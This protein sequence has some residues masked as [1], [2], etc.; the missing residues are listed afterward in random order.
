VLE[1]ADIELVRS[2]PDIPED[3]DAEIPQVGSEQRSE[4]AAM[5]DTLGGVGAVLRFALDAGQSTADL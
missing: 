4:P 5:L 1:D 2:L 3:R